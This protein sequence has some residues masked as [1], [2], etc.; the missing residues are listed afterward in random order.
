M[1]LLIINNLAAGPGDGAIYDFVR[2]FARDGDEF[3]MRCTDGTSSTKAM[4][5]DAHD[6]DAVVV[7]GGD[8]TISNVSYYLAHSGIPILPF[9]AGTANLLANNLA[10]PLEPH[11]LAKMMRENRILDFDLGEIETA[12]EKFGFCIMAGAGYDATIMHEAQPQKRLLGALAYFS[13]AL[14]NPT[15]QRSKLT[16]TYDGKEIEREG[17]GVLLVNFSKIQFDIGVTHENKPRDGLLYLVVLKADNALKL[18]PAVLAGILD[19]GGAYPSRTDALEVLQAQSIE[20]HADPPLQIQ[21]DGELANSTTPFRAHV[22]KHATRYYLS[23]EGYDA[24]SWHEAE[25]KNN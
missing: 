7:A 16:I 10:S 20:V 22:L 25:D 13:A 1:K 12:E 17:I 5:T 3:V 6:F 9:P 19:R 14:H 8:G 15:P 2:A 21:Y 23:E 24:F 18:I 11:G 4:V